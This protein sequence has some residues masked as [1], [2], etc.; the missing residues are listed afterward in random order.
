[1]LVWW[2]CD[3]ARLAQHECWCR[4]SK[5]GSPEHAPVKINKWFMPR[6][7]GGMLGDD[8][9]MREQ[10]NLRRRGGKVRKSQAGRQPD[11]VLNRQIKQEQQN[12]Q[13]QTLTP[14]AHLPNNCACELGPCTGPRRPPVLL[15]AS[16]E[17]VPTRSTATHPKTQTKL[18]DPTNTRTHTHKLIQHK[19]FLTYTS[20]RFSI[21]C[22]QIQYLDAIA[23]DVV[24][25]PIVRQVEMLADAL[26]CELSMRPTRDES[27]VTENKQSKSKRWP[28]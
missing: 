5:Y 11:K 25:H 15:W 19:G 20:N 3:V 9:D 10:E 7:S 22:K 16:Y 12:R 4:L 21:D 26:Q 17:F 8:A 14:Y 23:H 27:D 18:I 1:M 6:S 24:Q 2:S 13:S 28:L